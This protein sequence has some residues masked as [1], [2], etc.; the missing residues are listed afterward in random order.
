ML[1]NCGAGEDSWE[2]LGLQG[3]SSQSILKEIHPECPLEELMLK[4]KLQYFGHLSEELTHWKRPWWWERLKV[5]GEEYKREW[6]GWMA[7][8]T[9]WTWVLASSGSWWRTGK[10]GVL[11]SMESQRVGHNWTELKANLQCCD[12]FRWTAKGLSHTYTRI[13]SPSNSLWIVVQL[14]SCFRLFA[15]PWAAEQQASLSFT[16]SYSVLKFCVYFRPTRSSVTPRAVPCPSA[17]QSYKCP[18]TR[19]FF[20]GSLGKTKPPSFP[21]IQSQAWDVFWASHLGVEFISG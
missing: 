2:S 17:A 20:W 15:T 7:S 21:S 16:V 14:L 8:L 11:Q 3:K 19:I 1:L 4:L 12:S 9:L 5:G 13:H 6:D 18:Q 10:P